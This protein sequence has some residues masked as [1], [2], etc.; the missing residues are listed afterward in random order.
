MKGS[1]VAVVVMLMLLMLRALARSQARTSV[2]LSRIADCRRLHFAHVQTILKRVPRKKKKK[3]LVHEVNEYYQFPPLINY[4]KI[5]IVKIVKFTSLFLAQTCNHTFVR[6][7][8]W[9]FI[10]STDYSIP[11]KN[12]D[13]ISDSI[14]HYFLLCY[15][16]ILSLP[17][18]VQFCPCC[19]G[20]E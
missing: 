3:R 10:L 18:F 5:V 1:A 14:M 9:C 7:L 17:S 8:C 16:P 19:V 2:D 4:V 12:Q 20:A 13:E 11:I 15:Y 6:V